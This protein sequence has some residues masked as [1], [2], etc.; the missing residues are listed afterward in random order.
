M[1]LQKKKAELEQQLKQLEANCN[2]VMGAIQF[3]QQLIDEEE[4]QKQPDALDPTHTA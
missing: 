3:C 1:D 2:A 4:K